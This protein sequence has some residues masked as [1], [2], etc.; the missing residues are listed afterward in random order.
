MSALEK[1][2]QP[3]FDQALPRSP[4]EMDPRCLREIEMH[5]DGQCQCG[6]VAYEA[7]I[8]P[9]DVSICHCEDCQ[10]LTGTAYR[11]SVSARREQF[12]VT[13]G[14]PKL[15][16]KV[17]ASGRRR[18]Q[19]FCANC[20]SPIFTTGES[21]DA[22]KVG[23]RLGTINQRRKLQPRSQS[24]CSSALSWTQ[25]LRDLPQRDRE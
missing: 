16:I 15:Y 4:L 5:I 25:D 13:S 7:D 22:A 11:V 9:E 20:G 8:A 19:Y 23:I 3:D 2:C 24:W 12:W 10:R 14:E 21:D 17:A 6:Q 18:L 1:M